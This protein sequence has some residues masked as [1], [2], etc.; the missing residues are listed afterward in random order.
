LSVLGNEFSE[1]FENMDQTINIDKSIDYS[2]QAVEATQ[3]D[4]PQLAR[5]L[6]ILG[7][8]LAD[9]PR[10]T[11]SFEDLR[12]STESFQKAVSCSIGFPIVPISEGIYAV[13]NLLEEEKWN[14]A[15]DTLSDT[16]QILPDVIPTTNTRDNMQHTLRLLSGLASLSTSVFLKAGKSP[17]EALQAF[18]K[19]PGVIVSFLIDAR[20]DISIFRE[21]HPELWSRYTECPEDCNYGSRDKL[22]PARRFPTELCSKE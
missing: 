13:D 6:I 14:A 8:G 3:E 4:H 10:R 2:Q 17:L 1:Q 11:V 15:A 19:A 16:L 18:E 12:S 5:Y 9:R 22:D 7:F 21:S 20:S